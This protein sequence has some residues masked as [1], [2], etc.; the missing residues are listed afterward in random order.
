MRNFYRSLLI[1]P[2]LFAFGPVSASSEILTLTCRDNSQTERTHRIDLTNRKVNGGFAT[3]TDTLI[4]WSES[5]P[6]FD[7]NYTINRYSGSY[8]V[9]ATQ[10]NNGLRELFNGTCKQLTEKRF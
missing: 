8:K 1:A 2:V 5:L 3:V 6:S 4:W 10:R 9:D 7:V